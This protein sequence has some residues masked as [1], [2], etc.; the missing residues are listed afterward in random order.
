M[1][2]RKFAHYR[3]KAGILQLTLGISVI[4]SVLCA[5]MILL[6]YYNKLNYL[7]QDINLKLRNNSLSGINYLMASNR[8]SV[9]FNKPLQ[10]DLFGDGNDSVTLIRKPWGVFELLVS[11]ATQGAHDFSRAAIVAHVPDEKGKSALYMPD[12]N[13]PVYLA[14][15]VLLKGRVYASARKFSSGYIDG[16]DY[17]RDRFVYGDIEKSEA[18]MPAL[19]TTLL[20]EVGSILKGQKNSYLLYSTDRLPGNASFSMPDTNHYFSNQSIDLE[21]SIQGNLI[22]QSAIKIR[23][24][25]QSHLF[26]VILIAP[27]IDIDKGVIGSFQCFAERS[28]TVGAECFLQFPSALVLIGK[29]NDSTIVIRRDA[30]VQ[31]FAIIQGHSTTIGSKGT[32]KVEDK[33]IFHGMAYINGSSDIQG[34]LWGHLTTRSTQVKVESTVYGNYILDGEINASKR[35]PYLPATSLWGYSEEMK[36]AKWLP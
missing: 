35:S 1:S 3:V 34:E 26:N 10:I 30:I 9:P 7:R 22:I 32:F 6:A 18:T 21:D 4:I 23:V 12:N 5:S 15:D 25:S 33:G 19:D 16:K 13:A 2:V 31:G 27:E 28:I 24:T 29:D 17:K 8:E 14:G 36:I 20:W 11:E